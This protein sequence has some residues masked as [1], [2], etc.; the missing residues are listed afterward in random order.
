MMDEEY[1][2]RLRPI[3]AIALISIFIGGTIDLLLD[4]PKRWLSFHV[5]FELTMIAGA[6]VLATSLWLRWWRAERSM[7][8][9]RQSLVTRKAERDAWRESARRALEGLGRAVDEQFATW[10][11]TPAERQ[12][13]LHLMKG[14]SHKRI[15]RLTDRSEN[16]VRQ[17]A[18]AVYEK[19]GLAGR[20]ELAAFFLEDLML[21]DDAREVASKMGP[22]DTY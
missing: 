15:A 13:A 5:V 10:G 1:E 12:V 17:H 7:V 16:T 20:A 6:L 18:A 3:L 9:L 22:S 14:H 2:P 21:P 8:Q 11:L 19:A 4:A